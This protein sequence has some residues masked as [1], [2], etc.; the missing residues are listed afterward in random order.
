MQAKEKKK[1]QKRLP[2][3]NEKSTSHSSQFRWCHLYWATRHPEGSP[4]CSSV[5]VSR[6]RSFPLLEI[7][8]IDFV[9]LFVQQKVKSIR[10]ARWERET[11]RDI[12]NGQRYDRDG[13]KSQSQ[14]LVNAD[15][16]I[17][18]PRLLP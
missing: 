1:L 18:Y 15:Y 14:S 7:F 16:N 13:M 8:K 4:C 12:F 9:A 5:H 17:L 10:H 11:M 3:W 2:H 6:T